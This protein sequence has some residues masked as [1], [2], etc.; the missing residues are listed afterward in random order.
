MAIKL[1]GSIK[2]KELDLNGKYPDAF[3]KINVKE[4]DGDIIEG[5]ESILLSED[6]RLKYKSINDCF[7]EIKIKANK[8]NFKMKNGKIGKMTLSFNNGDK[9]EGDMTIDKKEYKKMEGKYYRSEI[10]AWIEGIFTESG[11]DGNA[12][13]TFKNGDCIE[14]K[15]MNNLL[16]GKGTI[17]KDEEYITGEFK[18]GLLNGY[19][20]I[21]RNGLEIKGNFKNNNLAQ[22]CEIYIDGFDIEKIKKNLDES[23]KFNQKSFEAIKI[24]KEK[25]NCFPKK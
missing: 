11:I 24:L 21:R 14:G 13:I 16:N 4:K 8:K 22:E 6:K 9:F 23:V 7:T 2:D 12:K 18:N 10:G 20:I 25:K 17:T 15:F 5:T 3:Y 19:G 1:D